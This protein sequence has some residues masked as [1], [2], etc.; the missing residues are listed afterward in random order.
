[1]VTSGNKLQCITAS[2]WLKSNHTQWMSSEKLVH[3]IPFFFFFFPSNANVNNQELEFCRG[4][5]PNSLLPCK[6]FCSSETWESH[7]LS[8]LTCWNK[9]RFQA[10]FTWCLSVSTSTLKPCLF[11]SL[12]TQILSFACTVNFLNYETFV[13]AACGPEWCLLLPVMIPG[14]GGT[15]CFRPWKCEALPWS[16]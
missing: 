9:H 8:Y 11:F 4:L 13:Q 10:A 7:V 2:N 14:P 16:A 12:W 3:N 1:M 5:R 15:C 6:G